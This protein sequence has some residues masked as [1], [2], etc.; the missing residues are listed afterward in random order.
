MYPA[1]VLVPTSTRSGFP[2]SRSN[3]AACR[4]AAQSSSSASPVVRSCSSRVVAA[5]VQLEA[6]DGLRVAAIEAFGQPQDRGERANRPR[7]FRV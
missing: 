4:A 6:G 3:A 2:I 7:R 5:V 1:A